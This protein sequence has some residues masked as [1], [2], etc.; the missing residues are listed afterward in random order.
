MNYVTCRKNNSGTVSVHSIPQVPFHAFVAKVGIENQASIAMF[1][2][3]GFHEV[4]RSTIWKE[5]EMRPTNI[6]DER[7]QAGVKTAP[8]QTLQWLLDDV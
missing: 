8:L 2:S 1:N 7:F 5:A 4:H 6:E 3:L